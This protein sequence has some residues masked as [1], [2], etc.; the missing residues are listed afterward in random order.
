MSNA[1]TES[2][3]GDRAGAPAG[4]PVSGAPSDNTTVT[5]VLNSFERRGFTEQLI[6]LDGAVIEC[7]GCGTRSP[8]GSFTIEGAR[9]LEGASD[10]DDMVTVIAA[11]CPQCA[12]V[13]TVV[14]GYGPSASEIDADISAAFG[15]IQ[16]EIQ[17][18]G[19]SEDHG[20]ED[21]SWFGGS[22]DEDPDATG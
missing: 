6:P 9:R 13:G 4:V 1:P 11:R 19:A 21:R 2:E 14:L 5:A 17:A 20:R 22:G 16:V 8:V 10:P 18:E 3:H 12:R 7:C 15:A